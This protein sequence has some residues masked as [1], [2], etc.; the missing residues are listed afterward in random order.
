M[1]KAKVILYFERIIDR[2]T[3]RKCSVRKGAFINFAKFTVKHLCQSL[4]FNK[5]AGFSLQKRDSGTGVFLWVLRN[6][7]KRFFYR[8]PYGD[9]FFI[10]IWQITCYLKGLRTLLKTLR[11][12]Y[13]FNGTLYLELHSPTKNLQTDVPH[14]CKKAL[15]SVSIL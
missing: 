5:V 14:K 9:C 11:F 10:K 4:F 2:S 1:P 12:V 3:H 13:Y 7:C 8:A 6:F 15:Y